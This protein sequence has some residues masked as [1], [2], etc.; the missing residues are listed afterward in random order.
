MCEVY[1]N[2]ITLSSQHLREVK[3]HHANLPSRRQGFCPQDVFKFIF[4]AP[5]SKTSFYF[6]MQSY[7]CSANPMFVELVFS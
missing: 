4:V 1:V 7:V 6:L 3:R 2:V 5:K